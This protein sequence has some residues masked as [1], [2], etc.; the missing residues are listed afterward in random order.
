[1]IVKDKSKLHSSKKTMI[2]GNGFVDS[3]IT[4]NK[5]LIAKPMSLA[6]LEG[7]KALIRKMT[8]EKNKDQLDPES[9]QILDSLKVPRISG[10]GLKRF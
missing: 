4:Q 5:D 9:K 8:A 10:S 6:M 3:Y 7:S 2:Y 1:M